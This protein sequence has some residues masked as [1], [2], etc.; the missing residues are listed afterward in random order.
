MLSFLDFDI[1]EFITI[2]NGF[3]EKT[4]ETTATRKRTQAIFRFED[5]FIAKLKYYAKM[6]DKSLNAF[7]E[8]ILQTEISR[9]ESLPKLSISGTYSPTLNKLSGILA[10]KI[11]KDD[12]ENNDRLAY[13][14][15]K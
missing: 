13:I 12:L 2:F 3:N 10:G 9:K 8:A 15:N 1:T 11:A 5:S 7:V 14:L 6:E 4:M